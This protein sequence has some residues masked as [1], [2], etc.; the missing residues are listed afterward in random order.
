MRHIFSLILH[1]QTTII[2]LEP[3]A[4]KMVS[5]SISYSD[6]V[7]TYFAD[8]TEKRGYEVK[9][10]PKT[11]WRH[12]SHYYCQREKFQESSSSS[13]HHERKILQ[14]KICHPIPPKNKTPNLCTWEEGPDFG[15]MVLCVVLDAWER[16]RFFFVSWCLGTNLG[17]SPSLPD[18][19]KQ[20]TASTRLGPSLR[21]SK[22]SH[23]MRKFT[24]A[25]GGSSSTVP[26]DEPNN[27][28]SF[29]IPRKSL[30]EW[31]CFAQPPNAEYWNSCWVVSSLIWS[32]NQCWASIE[33]C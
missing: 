8:T 23:A 22:E 24:Y 17:L 15:L 12:D 1:V 27:V 4:E 16:G 20:R 10:G 13:I 28:W 21:R 19:L 32:L 25:W 33:F 5:F 31:I 11:R 26:G 14:L 2:T 3:A 30:M 6:L 18:T 29:W 7:I 9:A